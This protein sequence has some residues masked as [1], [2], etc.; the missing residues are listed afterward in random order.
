M[1][2]LFIFAKHIIEPWNYPVKSI[3]IFCLWCLDVTYL[4]SNKITWSSDIISLL[5]A[6]TYGHDAISSSRFCFIL[7]KSNLHFWRNL[8][9][10]M[11]RLT[12]IMRQINKARL[13][14]IYFNILKGFYPVS[15]CKSLQQR[16]S[17]VK[18]TEFC[19]L[20]DT[21]GNNYIFF[22]L[23]ETK[24]STRFISIF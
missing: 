19:N 22:Y 5:A 10:D 2:P 13:P 20:F 12:I 8:L 14:R 21:K 18:K 17:S 3:L 4:A 15:S 9:R 6:L 11:K 7:R 24:K 23:T 1:I 16:G